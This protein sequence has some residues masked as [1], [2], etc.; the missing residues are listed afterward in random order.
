MRPRN[1]PLRAFA[2]LAVLAGVML[3][4]CSYP[5]RPY[6]MIVYQRDL[7]AAHPDT[8]F[9]HALAIARVNGGDSSDPLG[10]PTVDA[11]GLRQALQSSLG[12]SRLLADPPSAAR[13]DLYVDF[14]ELELPFAAFT[15]Y[16]V[17]SRIEYRVIEIE[18]KRIW[19]SDTVLGT[20]TTSRNPFCVLVYSPVFDFPESCDGT[21]LM[22]SANEGSIRENIKAFIERLLT[23]DPLRGQRLVN[24]SG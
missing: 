10:R 15:E 13:F 4:A 23:H 20:Y 1:A 2:L 14:S 6:N 12:L 11:E 17:T 5:A 19:F 7:V 16:P 3:G 22:R 21:D 18:T 8:P 9:R 24:S